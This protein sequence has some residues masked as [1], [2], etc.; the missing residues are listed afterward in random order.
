ML[1]WPAEIPSPLGLPWKESLSSREL[2]YMLLPSEGERKAGYINQSINALHANTARASVYQ[3]VHQFVF[4]YGGATLLWITELMQKVSWGI[5]VKSWHIVMSFWKVQ[6][7]GLI[8]QCLGPFLHCHPEHADEQRG[9]PEVLGS[10][11]PSLS[12]QD[13]GKWSWWSWAQC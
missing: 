10:A 5:Q 6:S 4:W 1:L 2:I 8:P 9:T 7:T 13:V 3:T 12:K 11:C